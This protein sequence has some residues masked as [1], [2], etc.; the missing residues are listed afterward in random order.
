MKIDVYTREGKIAGTSPAKNDLRIN[1]ND[2]DR[3]H[4]ECVRETVLPV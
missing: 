2:D 1:F 3:L 4:R